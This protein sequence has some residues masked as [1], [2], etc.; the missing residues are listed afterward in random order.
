MASLIHQLRLSLA[1]G[2]AL[3]QLAILGVIAGLITSGT[4]LLFRYAIEAP[5]AAY[6]ANGDHENFESLAP[7]IRFFLPLSGALLVAFIFAKLSTQSRMVGVSHVLERIKHHQGHMPLTNF[8]AQFF[9]GIICILSGQSS[10]REGP[11]VHLG[12][13][14]GSV[15]GRQF[16]L[17]SRHI[18]LLLASGVAAAI[19]ASFNTPI[20]GVIFAMEVIVM[21]FNFVSLIPVI[22]ASVTGALVTRWVYGTEPAFEVPPLEMRS[23]LEFPFL[24]FEGLLMGALAALFIW[25]CVRT[26]KLA[27]KSIWTRFLIIGLLNGSL[28]LALPAMMGIGYDTVNQAITGHLP[29]VIL[30]TY[31]LA[32][33][34]ITSLNLGLGQ[35]AGAIG[36]M[37]FI[38]ACAGGALGEL[39]NF[40]AP[41]VASANGYYAMLGMA[42]MMSAC[43]Q[44]PLTALMTLLELTNNPNIILPAMLVVV[45]ANLT[46]S[47]LFKQKSLF[48]RLLQLRGLS[49]DTSPVEQM[50]RQNS[51]LTVAEKNIKVVPKHATIDTLRLA[52]N[53]NPTW[54]VIHGEKGILG[55]LTAAD[56]ANLLMDEDRLSEWLEKDEEGNHVINLMAIPAQ[57][58]TCKSISMRAN[59]QE[60][61]D[62]MIDEKVECLTIHYG[63]EVNTAS[64]MGIIE[65]DK[66]HNYYR[67]TH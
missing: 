14:S 59:L 32:K 40:F 67:Y 49:T 51:V 22:L 15:M 1:Q 11:A 43:L 4:I 24:V 7:W 56:L 10:G 20:A 12:A 47:E 38:G 34:C 23:L 8:F 58:L 52:L 60:A 26:A 44:A 64:V 2:D 53:G 42:A 29:W 25:I 5:L 31:A 65:H 36:P 61:L 39:G 37:L 55:A 21:G 18:Q 30:L 57:R 50:L 13:A 66:I 6:L 62:I 46:A 19:S 48:P 27:P 16:E 33:L 3:P 63:K 35:P 45:I 28:A 17:P 41:D 54:L 9:A